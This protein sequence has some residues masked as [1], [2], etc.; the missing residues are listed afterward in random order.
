MTQALNDK[1]LGVL[2]AIVHGGFTPSS[3]AL[4]Q[5]RV[6]PEQFVHPTRRLNKPG[7]IDA[8]G[9]LD[10]PIHIQPAVMSPPPT[11]QSRISELLEQ[12]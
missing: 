6:E 10:D 11:A 1:E 9:N 8:G 4:R 7:D 5:S 3:K 2:E 12:A